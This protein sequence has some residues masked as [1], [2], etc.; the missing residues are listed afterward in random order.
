M[1]SK[2]GAKDS[3]IHRESTSNGWALGKL[4]SD[5][6]P[7]TS[8]QTKRTKMVT[9]DNVEGDNGWTEKGQRVQELLIPRKIHLSLPP[10][11][12]TIHFPKLNMT[13]EISDLE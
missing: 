7:K 8:D 13:L 6:V 4:A 2:P 12:F 9:F 5:K 3:K 1:N 11:L 10:S